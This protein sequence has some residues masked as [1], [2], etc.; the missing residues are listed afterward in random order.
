MR[1]VKQFFATSSIAAIA[2]FSGIVHADATYTNSSNASISSFGSPNTT[3]YGEY[4][5]APGGILKDFSFYAISGTSGNAELVI[6]NWNGSRAVGPALYTSAPISYSGGN[7]ILGATNIDLSLVSGSSYI[8]Y[9][10]V[11]GVAS[12][13]TGVTMA[14]SSGDGGLGGSFRYLNSSNVNPLTLNNAWS[15]YSVSNMA[16]S[17]SFVSNPPVVSAVPEPGTYVMLL[18]GLVL[19][20]GVTFRKRA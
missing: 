10:T 7:M 19:I 15:S 2:C 11:A 17:A 1:S 18:T 13:V 9:L 12:P 8:A 4:F 6:A 5:T 14:G 16:Y 20:S 3:S